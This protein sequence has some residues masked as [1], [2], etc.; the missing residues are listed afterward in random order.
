MDRALG[1]GALVVA[2]VALLVAAV[3]LW[4]ARSS[5]DPPTYSEITAAS[6]A[7]ITRNGNRVTPE[8]VRALLGNPAEIYRDNPRALCWRYTTPYEIRMCWGPKRQRPWIASSV[9]PSA[10]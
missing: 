6:I 8:Q 3:A 5:D 1:V 4:Q 7:E 2:V 9:P 10:P